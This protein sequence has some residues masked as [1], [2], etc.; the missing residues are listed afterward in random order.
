MQPGGKHRLT[1]TR[2]RSSSAC[3]LHPDQ[4]QLWACESAELSYLIIE[5]ITVILM[6]SVQQ[7]TRT[8]TQTIAC[9][10]CGLARVGQLCSV[11]HKAPE[12]CLHV[13]QCAVTRNRVKPSALQPHLFFPLFLCGEILS[14][15]FFCGLYL[16]ETWHSVTLWHC[17]KAQ[18]EGQL[19][20]GTIWE[21]KCWEKKMLRI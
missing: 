16:S 19:Q 1:E 17:L 8:R 14:H 21:R 11:S 15:S 18:S 3:Q 13:I 6:F 9:S 12:A 2:Q 7:L 4:R 20:A 10:L 5:L